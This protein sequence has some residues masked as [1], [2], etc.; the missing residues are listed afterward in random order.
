M[1]DRKAGFAHRTARGHVI[2]DTEGF[3]VEEV[4]RSGVETCHQC[5]FPWGLHGKRY[6]AEERMRIRICPE[7]PARPLRPIQECIIP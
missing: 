3:D 4:S 5:H 1:S 7:Y 6:D 2:L